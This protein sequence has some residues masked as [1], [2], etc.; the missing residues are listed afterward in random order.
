[1]GQVFA[2]TGG[3]GLLNNLDERDWIKNYK[4]ELAD[5]VERQRGMNIRMRFLVCEGDHFI[6]LSPEQYRAIP[7]VLFQQTPYFVYADRVAFITWE[8]RRVLL[9]QNA[10]M[11]D[12]FRSQFEFNWALGRKL[13]PKKIIKAKLK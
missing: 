4:D 2:T 9:I 6:V 13:D 3:E 10:A 7:E 12:T 11:A 5:I 8:P 1:M